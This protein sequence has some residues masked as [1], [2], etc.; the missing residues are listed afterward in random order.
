MIDKEELT[1][2]L[3]QYMEIK[4]KYPNA[5]V[6][7][8]MGDFYE[9]FYEDAYIAARELGLTLT[10]R[11][12]E[13]KVPLAG[14]P[15]HAAN[16]Y[17][18]KLVKKGYKVVICEQIGEPRA[19][20]IVEREVVRIVTPGTIEGEEWEA[21][22]I[23][24]V[25]PS[26]EIFGLSYADLIDGDFYLTEVDEKDLVS[27]IERLSPAELLLPENI[28][29]E[30]IPGDIPRTFLPKLDFDLKNAE[31]VLK[32]HFGVRS[33]E[34]FGCK[35]KLNGIAAAGA[36]L[37]Y[38][39]RTQLVD[40]KHIT[41]IKVQYPKDFMVLDYTTQKNLEL[42][43]SLHGD[44]E[45]TL[46]GV[47]NK[48]RT[49]MG[50]RL[51]K[52]WILKPLRS[53][54]KIRERLSR[55]EWFCNEFNS[56]RKVREALSEMYDIDRILGRIGLKTFT[57]KD[58][59][60]LRDSLNKLPEIIELL[61]NVPLFDKLLE[62]IF[63][64]LDIFE[65]LDEVLVNLPPHSINDED[66]VKIGY[67]E[68]L[69]ELK[70][71]LLEGR[72][73]I[74]SFE[75][76]ERKRT[77]IKSLKVGYN[78]VFG[79]YIEVTKSNVNMIP[80]DYERKQTLAQTERFVTKE[81]KEYEEKILTAEEKILEITLRIKEELRE[82]VLRRADALKRLSDAIAEIDVLS[83]LA[84]VALEKGYVKPEITDSDLII[85]KEG[86]HPVVEHFIGK[87][88]FIPNDIH[89]EP[90]K[91]KIMVLT[92]PNMAGKSTYLRQI[93]HIVI[94]AQMG[95]FVP[96]KLA[97]IGLVDRIFTR[98]GAVDNL[99]R[100]ESTFMIEMAETANI[101]RNATSKSLIILDEIGR[102]T[103]T[104]DGLSIAWAVIEYLY[105]FIGAKVLFAT[106][107][108]ELTELE[109][110][111]PNLK[112]YHMAVED[113]GGELTFLYKVKSGSINKSYGIEVARIA[114]LPSEVVRRAN[115]ILRRLEKK[116]Q[117]F[118]PPKQLSLF[119][120]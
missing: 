69:D 89:L 9:M 13:K 107:Y 6:F 19:G 64:S 73:W 30:E 23:A 80:P 110:Y 65:I 29:V 2:A 5:I 90:S 25:F 48:T 117:E 54:E 27:E 96:A 87:E 10:S 86:R 92:G 59:A 21:N 52:L 97:K 112:N 55:V 85:I 32:K 45:A 119:F 3:K 14:V 113:R 68:E 116:E 76:R 94:M 111:L 99:S 102:G 53:K 78:K 72:Q 16:A 42:V 51:L 70:N 24:S 109:K 104:Y 115:E 118:I 56:L 41:Q 75:E 100:G 77:G 106:H 81:L 35:D 83:S 7:F 20:K 49:P 101:L 1:P 93:A 15:Y 4:E 26:G 46:F 71:L 40:L 82:R 98:I 60:M 28:D 58:L 61:E 18:R 120:G 62:P 39:Q 105:N 108:H 63:E 36:L 37:S 11:D 88:R 8:R 31:E 57:A 33:L 43:R 95:S 84:F 66:F 17:L 114:G 38:L 67:D 22:Y 47:L 34:A 79:Y 12:R 44:D 74:A 50:K 103:S 91:C